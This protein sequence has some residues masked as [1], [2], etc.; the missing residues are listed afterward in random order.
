[1]RHRLGQQTIRMTTCPRTLWTGNRHCSVAMRC[2]S[3]PDCNHAIDG[4]SGDGSATGGHPAIDCRPR[5]NGNMPA[6]PAPNRVGFGGT[7]HRRP[8]RLPGLTPIQ[9]ASPTRL[10]R[11]RPIPGDC[12]TCRATSGN[13]VGIG[14]RDTTCSRAVA[15][16]MGRCWV[17]GGG[18]S[19]AVRSSS[20]PGTCALRPGSGTCPRAGSRSSG[21]VAFAVRSASMTIE[22]LN[23]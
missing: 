3:R 19:A 16:R 17:S 15:I 2:R 7:M 8:T 5:R 14:G 11:K 23:H 12:S 13:G 20:S 10:A 1:M 18:C 4:A 22:S 6:A 9:M 21:S